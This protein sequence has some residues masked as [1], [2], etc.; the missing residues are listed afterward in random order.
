MAMGHHHGWALMEGYTTAMMGWPPIHMN[1]YTL[2]GSSAEGHLFFPPG[3]SMKELSLL[4]LV[5]L[6]VLGMLLDG[7]SLMT[8]NFV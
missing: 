1:P 3:I 5:D 8:F 2:L 4:E 6:L 7:F